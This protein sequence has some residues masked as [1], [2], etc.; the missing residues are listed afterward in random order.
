[1]IDAEQGIDLSVRQAMTCECR[2][3]WLITWRFED[4]VATTGHD[5]AVGA[6]K[7]RADGE[8]TCAIRGPCLLETDLPGACQ[9]VPELHRHSRQI[10][11]QPKT[12]SRL[13]AAATSRADPDCGYGRRVTTMQHDR[14]CRRRRA[15]QHRGGLRRQVPAASLWLKTVAI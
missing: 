2:C 1:M 9:L 12:C 4:S 13:V 11:K 5:R 6:D 3:R 15:L 10:T 8:R 14:L 7:D